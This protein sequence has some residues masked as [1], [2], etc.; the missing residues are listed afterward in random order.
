MA[1]GNKR[2]VLRLTERARR[3]EHEPGSSLSPRHAGARGLGEAEREAR[4]ARFL[5]AQVTL[6]SGGP[7]GAREGGLERSYSALAGMA[8][9][10]RREYVQLDQLGKR[11]ARL[12]I[13][14]ELTRHRAGAAVGRGAPG[15]QGPST[16]GPAS[17]RTALPVRPARDSTSE[18][19]VM[20]D[21]REI[22]ARRRR[23]LGRE[24]P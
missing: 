2:R 6:P 8:G 18:S 23:Q 14:R 11:A 5:E 21:A 20:R 22:A 17:N 1:V 12:Q 16:A 9:Y 4:H 10:G 24:S 19:E 15:G 13:D 7:A 3:I